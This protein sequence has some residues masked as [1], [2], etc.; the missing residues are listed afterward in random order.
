M[1]LQI[2]VS[3]LFGLSR[4][5]A[6]APAGGTFLPAPDVR[7]KAVLGGRVDPVADL[8]IARFTVAAAVQINVVILVHQ[9][10]ASF[11][12]SFNAGHFLAENQSE[13][14]PPACSYSKSNS[15]VTIG[16]L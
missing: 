4:L 15:K 16:G 10:I 8:A 9:N 1:Y 12:R 3:Q 5:A 14:K 13:E 11:V 7:L 6:F 2:I